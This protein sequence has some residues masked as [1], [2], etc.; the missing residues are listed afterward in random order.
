MFEDFRELRRL[1]DRLPDE[2]SA[3][4]VGR[5]GITGSRR[6]MLVRHFAEH[7]SFDCTITRRNPLTAEKTA[8]SASERPAGESEVVSAD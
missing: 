7:P 1:F 2:F 8:E 6:H 5:T 3:D 4:D